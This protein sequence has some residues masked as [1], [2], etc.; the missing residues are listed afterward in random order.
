MLLFRSKAWEFI[1]IQGSDLLDYID[2]AS[3]FEY[4]DGFV[5]IPQGPG[6]GIEINESHV[7]KMAAIGHNWR[8]PIR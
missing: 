7:R 5:N 2:D 4:M 3:V 6:L 1:I 8:N